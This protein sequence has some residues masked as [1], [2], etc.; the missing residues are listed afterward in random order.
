[1]ALPSNTTSTPINTDFP[2]EHLFYITSDDP[3]YD[4]LLIYLQTQKFDNHLSRDDHRCIHH[5]APSTSSSKTSYT[6]EG[7]IL[8]FVDA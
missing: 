6:G 5:Q 7:L 8:F 1:M 2:D 4:D 3:W